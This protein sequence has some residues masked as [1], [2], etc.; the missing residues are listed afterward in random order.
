VFCACTETTGKIVIERELRESEDHY[1][2]TV[3]LNPQVTWTSRPEG[4]LDHVA[5]RW[6]EWTGTSGLGESW[7]EAIHPDDLGPT[8]DAWRLSVTT[9]APYDIE[10]RVRLRDGE[11]HWM[12]SRSFPRRDADGRI[13]KWYGS[14]EDIHERKL[15]ADLLRESEAR[16]R[17]MA[18]HAPVKI[19][20]TD[21]DGN[22]TYLSRRWYQFTGQ[23]TAE[24]LGLGWTK[25]THPDD[26]ARRATRSLRPTP[27]R[28]R[29]RSSTGFAAPTAS[30][31][32]RST[33]RRRA[34]ARAASFSAMSARSSTSTSA[35]T[36][37][38]A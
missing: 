35:A 7:G 4:Q 17:N 11:Y 32:G 30:I 28:A 12:R 19:W 25:A 16:F 9:G 26:E 20:I 24:A 29:S 23:T 36:P 14:T 34:S 2:H 33:R 31:A 3:E 21:P 15:A 5:R 27:R 38:S 10:H 6:F 37:R 8:V 1:R 18:D 22:C 13:V